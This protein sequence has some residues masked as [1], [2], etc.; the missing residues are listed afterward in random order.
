MAR[1]KIGEFTVEAAGRSEFASIAAALHVTT[2]QVAVAMGSPVHEH[3]AVVIFTPFLKPE[4]EGEGFD[5][6]QVRTFRAVVAIDHEGILRCVDC[7]EIS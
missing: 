3:E 2:H 4:G 7:V 1:E 5:P 6:E